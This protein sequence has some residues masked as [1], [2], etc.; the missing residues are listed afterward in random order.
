MA[1]LGAVWTLEGMRGLGGCPRGCCV[2][3]DAPYMP[4]EG[5]CGLGRAPLYD[6]IV[7][8]EPLMSLQG[9]DGLGRGAPRDAAQQW[10][11]H[12]H[13]TGDVYCGQGVPVHLPGGGYTEPCRAYRSLY[14]TYRAQP[15]QPPLLAPQSP[16]PAQPSCP[17]EGLLP[18]V[19]SI[20]CFIHTRGWV[21]WGWG[22]WAGLLYIPQSEATPQLAGWKG[23]VVDFV[24]SLIDFF[25][26]F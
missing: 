19:V 5:L 16:Q 1:R 6:D 9:T 3:V 24:L 11:T 22:G 13:S 14:K 12:G 8:A 20:R 15:P 7:V 26:L 18:G 2:M 4:P 17:S 25:A 10:M 23:G 21:G